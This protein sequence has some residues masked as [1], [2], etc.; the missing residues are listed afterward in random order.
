MI[1]KA[2]FSGSFNPLHNGHIDII[3]RA[4]KLFDQL[5]I[6]VSHNIDKK[7]SDDIEQRFKIAKT[8]VDKL[9]LRNVKVLMNKGLTIDLVK[10]LKCQYLVRSIRSVKDIGYEINMAQNN[11]LL[12]NNIETIFFVASSKLKDISSTNQRELIRQKQLIKGR[13]R[14]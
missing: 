2:V 6:A 13:K 5:Y 10:K 7:A 12:S 8:K 9:K 3:K 14:D 11:H 4:A 1:R